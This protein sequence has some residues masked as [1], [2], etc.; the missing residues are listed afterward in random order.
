MILITK[1]LL[2]HREIS[3]IE[4]IELKVRRKD[5]EKYKDLKLRKINKRHVILYKLEY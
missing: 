3:L 4:D 1:I 5:F 2:S